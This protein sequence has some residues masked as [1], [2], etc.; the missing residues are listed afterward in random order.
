MPESELVL[1]LKDL[2]SSI[3]ELKKDRGIEAHTHEKHHD[4]IADKIEQE[5]HQKELA[6][7]IKNKSIGAVVVSGL[8]GFLYFVGKMAREYLRT[9][10]I[11]I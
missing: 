4:Y 11:H 1:I 7:D 6:E 3:D 5:E 8:M 9:I 10:G 2:K